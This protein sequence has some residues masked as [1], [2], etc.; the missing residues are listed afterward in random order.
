MQ[1]SISCTA[2]TW[3]EAV[4]KAKA[5]NKLIFIDFYTQ[6]CGPCL[7]MAQTVSHCLQWVTTITKLSST[8]K[9]M[10][11]KV[12]ELHSQKYG[13]RSYPTYHS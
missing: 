4:A 5:E 9:L 11:K 13:V 3:A 1:E 8:S 2:T 10:L 6:W 12:K 7:N